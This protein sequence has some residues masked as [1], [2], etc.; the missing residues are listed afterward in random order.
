M[1]EME[2]SHRSGGV[3]V[4]TA[5]EAC[6]FAESEAHHRVSGW[7]SVVCFRLNVISG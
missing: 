3:A 7:L 2:P 1:L 4:Q 6:P 5:V